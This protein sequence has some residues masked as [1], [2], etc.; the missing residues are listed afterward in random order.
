MINAGLEIE[1]DVAITVFVKARSRAE[2]WGSWIL[3]I[4]YGL[5]ILNLMALVLTT[6]NMLGY[7]SHV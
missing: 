4:G 1:Q 3:F 5:V 7:I 2:K 6:L